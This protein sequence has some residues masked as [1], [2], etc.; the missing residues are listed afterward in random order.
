MKTRYFI[1]LLAW[2]VLTLSACS[3]KKDFVKCSNYIRITTQSATTFTEDSENPVIV[4]VMLAYTLTRDETITFELLDNQGDI[5]YIDT[6]QLNFKAG[7]KVKQFHVYS[8]RKSSLSAQQVV[9]L[10]VK[11]FTAE[12]MLPWEDGILLTVKPDADIPELNEEQLQMIEGYK[13]NMNLDIRRMMGKLA[14][15]VRVVFPIDEVGADGETVFSDK[16]IQEF[17]SES[18]LTLSEKA[19]ANQP[20][21]KIVDNPMGWSSILWSV[22]QKEIAI[23]NQV[24]TS[25]PSVVEAV[26]YEP[27]SEEFQIALDSL[28]VHENQK[29]EFTGAVPDAYG[30]MIT[31]IPFI[32][33]FSAWNRQWDMAQKGS[34]VDVVV[35]DPSTGEILY[36][37]PETPMQS[38]IEQGITLS[39]DYY[40]VSSDITSDS[41][42]SGTWKAPKSKVDFEKGTWNFEFSWDHQNSSGWTLVEVTYQLHPLSE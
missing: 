27:T 35:K 28:I 36:T 41:W 14:C 7:E 5:L 20:I 30:N 1:Y 42:K 34:T 6:P 23:N 11:N 12:D 25:F 2:V 18:I 26:H 15:H 16:E 40:L 4:D 29:V 21:L 10:K 17:D 9:A 19:T 38:L 33:S 3:D 13:K 8:N 39:P 22:L 37:E 24:G 31:A 32:Y